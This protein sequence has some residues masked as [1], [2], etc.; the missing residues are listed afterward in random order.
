LVDYYIIAKSG[1]NEES[2]PSAIA[3]VGAHHVA[4]QPTLFQFK[5]SEMSVAEGDGRAVITV[6]RSGNLSEAATI[7]YITKQATASPDVDYQKMSG[8][9]LFPQGVSEVQYE[10]PILADSLNEWSEQ[11]YTRLSTFNLGASERVVESSQIIIS[12]T[13]SDEL[14]FTDYQSQMTVNETDGMVTISVDR[15]HPSQRSIS[16]DLAIDTPPGSAVVDVDYTGASPWQIN[17]APGQERSSVTIPLLDDLVKDGYKTINFILNNPGGGSCIS[18][19]FHQLELRIRDNETK[20]GQFTIDSSQS[21]FIANA[22]AD[23][24]SVPL[25]R[26][27]GSDGTISAFVMV[28]GGNTPW[29]AITTTPDPLEL[30]EGV[31]TGNILITLD[32]TN[33]NP[34]IA[35]TGIV[36]I[37][38]DEYPEES[39]SFAVV[40]SHDDS[41]DD[42]T[43]W[44]TNCGLSGEKSGLLDD[45]D[46][47]HLPNL[48]ELATL[49]DPRLATSQSGINMIQNGDNFWFECS[50]RP[51]PRLAVF[52]E[53]SE[54]LNMS[55][56]TPSARHW[57]WDEGSQTYHV[58]FMTWGGATNHNFG[59]LRFIWLGNE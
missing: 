28:E 16:I 39:H 26:I 10:I 59:R 46:G 33:I 2:Q 54:S 6:Q 3:C 5:V 42:F 57:T 53:F 31:T 58:E 45:P 44:A 8:T 27:G 41:A 20:P 38:N 43:T 22:G 56:S 12:I 9:L 52:A 25:S 51:S 49:S 50:V 18:Q 7:R 35:P 24:L 1:G 32:R 11:F 17:F 48:I 34:S 47:D 36:T 13:E 21:V 14:F 23:T 55:D 37:I 15:A 29:G 4:N 40:F 19:S 30:A